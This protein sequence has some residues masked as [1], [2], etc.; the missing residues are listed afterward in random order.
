M[1]AEDQRSQKSAPV[2]Y[3]LW[4]A[5]TKCTTKWAVILAHAHGTLMSAA[6]TILC[7]LFDVKSL[8][9]TPFLPSAKIKNKD[10]NRQKMTFQRHTQ[11]SN[12]FFV[13]IGYSKKLLSHYP[14]KDRTAPSAPRR[15]EETTAPGEN[16]EGGFLF[17]SAQQ[18]LRPVS[19]E[20]LPWRASSCVGLSRSVRSRVRRRVDWQ[21]RAN[22][23]VRSMNEIFGRK[24]TS[25]AGSRPSSMQLFSLD[26]IYAAEC[27]N[28]A[29]DFTALCGSAPGHFQ[30]HLQGLLS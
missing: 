2:V 19:Q 22:A 1:L 4:K 16:G 6:R 13:N 9:Q 27:N 15:Q 26:R 11:T 14:N 5:Q 18:V 28:A 24:S 10:D 3:G 25:E 23:G 20:L 21:C 17:N 30:G 8:L 12:S 7:S 29:E